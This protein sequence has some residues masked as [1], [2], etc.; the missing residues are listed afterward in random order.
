M[1]TL[2]KLLKKSKEV[3][4]IRVGSTKDLRRRKRQ[5]EKQGYVGLMYHTESQN[6]KVDEDRLLDQMEKY[7]IKY[8]VYR[9]SGAKAEPG[10]VYVIQGRRNK[11]R[12]D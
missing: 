2:D 9:K 4:S 8:N 5:Y 11:L 10:Y 3:G 7:D 6:M 12:C 1:T